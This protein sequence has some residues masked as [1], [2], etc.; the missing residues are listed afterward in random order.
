MN[1]ALI[2]VLATFLTGAVWLVWWL[3]VGRGGQHEGE[4]A[5]VEWCRAFFPVLLIVLILRSFVAEPFR[6][7]S[8]S[9]MPTLLVGDFILVNKFAYGLRLPVLETKILDLGEPERGDVAVFRYP[10]APEMDYIKRVVGVPGDEVAYRD[11]VLYLN[12]RKVEQ[13]VLE[14][15]E[16]REVDAREDRVIPGSLLIEEQLNAQHYRILVNPEGSGMTTRELEEGMEIPEGK[17]LMLG[18]NRDN[19]AD[20]RHWGL[21]PEDHLRGRALFVWLSWEMFQSS[22]DWGR[23]G[24]RIE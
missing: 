22:P 4:P 2:L 24:T 20:S 3:A 5:V 1:F 11:Q 18:D 9:M 10:P 17:Y 6:I 8:A 12:G 7:P 15:F 19:S 21:V 16:A 14:P 23:I 13:N